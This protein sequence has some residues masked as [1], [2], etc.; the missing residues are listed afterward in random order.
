MNKLLIA[1]P[2]LIAVAISMFGG[3]FIVSEGNQALITQFGKPVGGVNLPGLHFKIPFIQEVFRFES[4]IMKWDGDPR[5]IT[6]KDKKFIMVDSTARWRIK[7]PL[8]FFKTVASEREALSR[9]DDIVD[10]AVRDAVS[11]HLLVELVRGKGYT[12]PQKGEDLPEALADDGS[13]VG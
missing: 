3:F 13:L 9:L 4:R 7:D 11:A 10:S 5:E 6:T 12:P 1:V 2:I 8:K